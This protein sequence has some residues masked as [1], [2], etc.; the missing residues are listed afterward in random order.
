MF[1]DI[2][3]PQI[4]GK[5]FFRKSTVIFPEISGIIPQEIYGNFPT[6]NPSDIVYIMYC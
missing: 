3:I 5:N 2:F 1:H 4:F 6:Y